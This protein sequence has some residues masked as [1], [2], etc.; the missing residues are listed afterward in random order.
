MA[1]FLKTIYTFLKD[2]SRFPKKVQI[3]VWRT[4]KGTQYRSLDDGWMRYI[5]RKQ[6]LL[7]FLSWLLSTLS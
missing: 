6:D 1:S 5:S 4:D 7:L 3:Q 2:R